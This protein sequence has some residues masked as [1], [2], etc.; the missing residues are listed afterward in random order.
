[1]RKNHTTPVE[2]EAEPSRKT[3][4]E[5]LAKQRRQPQAILA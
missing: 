1:M 5:M 3:F 2:E 4:A